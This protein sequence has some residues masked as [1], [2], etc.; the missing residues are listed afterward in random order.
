MIT[1]KERREMRRMGDS[2]KAV[3]EIPRNGVRFTKYFKDEAECERFT[4][5]A[6]TYANRQISKEVIG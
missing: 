2:V 6:A 3:Y 4:A 5:A 1:M